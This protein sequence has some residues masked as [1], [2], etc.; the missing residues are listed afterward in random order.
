MKKGS[1]IWAAPLVAFLLGSG[2][3]TN[4]VRYMTTL[5]WVSVP[6]GTTAPSA[7]TAPGAPAAPTGP[8]VAVDGNRTLY[9]TFWEGTCSSG[10]LGF[11]KGCSL[12]DSKIR[13]CNVQADNAMACVDEQEANQAFARKK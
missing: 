9:V 11:G 3:C 13:R 10:I 12:G 8:A 6:G 1:M 7:Q 5:R 4:T 2:G